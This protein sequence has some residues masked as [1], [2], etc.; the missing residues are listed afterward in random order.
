M[1]STQGSGARRAGRWILDLALLGA[2][3]SAVV[4]ALAGRWEETVRFVLV[5]AAIG[6]ARGAEVPA[7]FGAAFSV[8]IL[9]AMWASAQ[10]WYR[11]LPQFDALVHFLTPGS[12]AA[13]AYFV[14]VQMRL[15]PDG[16]EFPEGLR[17]WAPVAW[18]TGVGVTVAV[19]WEFYEWIVEQIAPQGMI[20][21]YTD[22]VVDL[23][24]G[25]L[26]SLVAGALVLRWSRNHARERTLSRV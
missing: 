12:V 9:L 21:G 15:L 10:H 24:A 19:V 3:A 17:G 1:D 2:L 14:L 26:G 6:A 22:T 7:P 20:V 8:F 13:V 25:M 5:T 4:M 16:R 23:F 18:V 11:E